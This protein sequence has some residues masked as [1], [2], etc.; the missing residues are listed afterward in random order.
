MLVNQRSGVTRQPAWAEIEGMRTRLTAEVPAYVALPELG[1]R[2][3]NM[4]RVALLATRAAEIALSQAGLLDADGRLREPE[5]AIV[6]GSTSGSPPA[7]ETVAVD[8]DVLRDPTRTAKPRFV[9]MLSDTTSVNLACYFGARGRV[10][11]TISACTS[12][13]Q[14]IGQAYEL[15]K[16]GKVRFA[17]AGGAE[18]CHVI[19][20]AVFDIMHS[21]STLHDDPIATPRPFDRDR[22][23]LVVGEG[24]GALVLESLDSA[25]SRGVPIFGEILGYASNSDG[26]HIVNPTVEEMANVQREALTDAGLNPDQIDYVNAHGT[27]TE[28]GD[29]AESQATAAVFDKTMA[30]SSL[31]SYM[32][33]TLG[34]CGAV[35]AWT[36]LQ[37]SREGWILPTIHLDNVDPRCAELDYV[38]EVRQA[39]TR[40]MMSNN[41]AFGGINTS[42]VLSAFIDGTDRSLG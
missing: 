25:M 17:L 12:G 5:T 11:S 8:L 3:E 34:A 35:E 38:R 1:A 31:K 14:A 29:I 15:I 23:G 22:D 28:V 6:F 16:R 7:I 41:F 13:S 4:G 42:L 26:R 24:A 37:M 30:I 19:C 20:S 33:H 21:T 27:A 39:K 9:Q 32:G 2:T 36:L 10:I 40:Y 18:E